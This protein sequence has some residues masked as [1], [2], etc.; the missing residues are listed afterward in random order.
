MPELTAEQL[1]NAGARL[2]IA[3]K[4]TR[5][6]LAVQMYESAGRALAARERGAAYISLRD[7][8][9]TECATLLRVLAALVE[10]EPLRW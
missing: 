4:H 2:L 6:L 10:A 5:A 8:S 7:E 9:L 3:D 1:R